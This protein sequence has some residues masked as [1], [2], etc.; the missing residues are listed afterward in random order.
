MPI[1]FLWIEEITESFGS[2]EKLLFFYQNA[3]NPSRIS[4]VVKQE[5]V[6]WSLIT[7]RTWLMSFTFKS[8]LTNSSLTKTSIYLHCANP[9][10]VKSYL[11]P[12]LSLHIYL[13]WL[14]MTMMLRVVMCFSV[15]WAII[16][17]GSEKQFFK[18][19]WYIWYS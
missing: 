6:T 17:E 14:K 16:A 15:S 8:N 7:N 12:P 2:N 19:T 3:R 5:P 13:Q 9:F 4:G 1:K 18:T 10:D 11:P